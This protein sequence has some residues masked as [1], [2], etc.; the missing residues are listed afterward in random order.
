MPSLL[1]ASGSVALLD[2]LPDR[3]FGTPDLY[4]KHLTQLAPEALFF[5][6][7]I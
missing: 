6:V 3:T 5:A 4:K 7:L 2:E 1:M